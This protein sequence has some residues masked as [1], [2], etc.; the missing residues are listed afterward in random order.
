MPTL[1]LAEVGTWTDS[2]LT[3]Q[4]ARWG[5][6]LVTWRRVTSTNTTRFSDTGAGAAFTGF[7]IVGGSSSELYV[8]PGQ[9]DDTYLY[10]GQSDNIDLI[11]IDTAG[12]ITDVGNKTGT[13]GEWN[14]THAGHPSYVI[15]GHSVSGGSRITRYTKPGGGAGTDLVVSASSFLFEV[16]EVDPA[17]GDI[18]ASVF[19]TGASRGVRKYDDTGTLLWSA[20]IPNAS[21]GTAYVLGGMALTSQGLVVYTVDNDV[22][23]GTRVNNNWWL[24]DTSTGTEQLLDVTLDGVPYETWVGGTDTLADRDGC[25]TVLDDQVYIGAS[26][27]RVYGGG[28]AAS[29]GRWRVGRVGWAA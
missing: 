2:A 10:L 13:G 26:L 4:I 5:D 3:G 21:D 29:P 24:L 27:S 19:F 25:L 12:T 18:Y 7:D 17:S 8:R 14:M 23:G 6:S 16:I 11:R 28:F 1:E 22:P 20:T 15:A 9:G